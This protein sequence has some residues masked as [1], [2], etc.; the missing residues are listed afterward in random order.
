MSPRRTK[1]RQTEK[2]SR[3]KNPRRSTKN[4]ESDHHL[5]VAILIVPHDPGRKIVAVGGDEGGEI[6]VMGHIASNR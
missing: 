6:E 3:G 2:A 5:Q 4:E 1:N